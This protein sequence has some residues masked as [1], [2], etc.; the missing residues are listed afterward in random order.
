TEA[1]RVQL[2]DAA[3]SSCHEGLTRLSSG[4]LSTVQ[5]SG[6]QLIFNF[7]GFL[8][9]QGAVLSVSYK[10]SDGTSQTVAETLEFVVLPQSVSLS[11]SDAPHWLVGKPT[12]FSFTTDFALPAPEHLSASFE[13]GN[14]SCESRLRGTGVTETRQLAVPRFFYRCN[15]VFL[16]PEPFYWKDGSAVNLTVD[17]SDSNELET[18]HSCWLQSDLGNTSLASIS[19]TNSSSSYLLNVSQSWGSEA[20]LLCLVN[21][22]G[23]FETWTH[24]RLPTVLYPAAMSIIL[25]DV[26]EANSS[27][28]FSVSVSKGQPQ[29]TVNCSLSWQGA[30]AELPLT[31]TLSGSFNVTKAMHNGFIS[32]SSWSAREPVAL[33]EGQQMWVTVESIEGNPEP[34]QR[35][36]LQMTDGSVVQLKASRVYTKQC[37]LVSKFLI[38]VCSEIQLRTLEVQQPDQN[39]QIGHSRLLANITVFC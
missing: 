27:V 2:C 10:C 25:Q 21:Q 7:T 11:L 9:M 18:S 5:L 14:V 29:P 28:N 31:P 37:A 33:K 38:H 8:W 16:M 39:R 20:T 23:L 1:A 24:Q 19:D 4:E 17:S 13:H 34:K 35:C 15:T 30:V 26:H 12:V 3:G 22:S 32:R 36:W 6:N